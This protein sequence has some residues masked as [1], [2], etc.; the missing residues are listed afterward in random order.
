MVKPFL[1]IQLRPED[2]TAENELQA[3]KRYGNLTD[4]EVHNLRAERSD[5]HDIDLQRYSAII[6][7]GSPFDISTAVSEKS[8][9]QLRIES[10]FRNLFQQIIPRDFPFL[11]CCSGSGLLGSYLGAPVSQKFAEPVGGTTLQLTEQGKRDPLLKDFPESFRVLLGH[12]EACDSTPPGAVLLASNVS[13]P[14]QMFRL[15]SNIY[16]TQFHPEADAEGFRV[17]IN[18]Y[19]DFGYF[20]ADSAKKL[21]ESIEN[22]KVPHAQL[23]L[24]RFVEI[25]RTQG[26]EIWETEA[27]TE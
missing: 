24:K 19:K 12:K 11:G 18:S 27:K 2:V 23:I 5:L 4:N 15:K 14:V 7:G 13:C 20:P 21:I 10:G 16:A 3:I 6:V 1:I 25:Y 26:A 17:R 9:T 8:D 22:E